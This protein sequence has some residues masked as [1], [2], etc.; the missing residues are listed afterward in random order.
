[1]IK[2]FLICAAAVL[3][4]PAYAEDHSDESEEANRA[5]AIRVLEALASGDVSVLNE[6]FADDGSNHVAGEER[7]RNGPHATFIEAASFVGALSDRKVDVF[8]TLADDNLVTVRSRL[9]GNHTEASIL[10]IEP[11]GRRICGHYTN[12]YRFRDGKIIDNY[13]AN[14]GIQIVRQLR[15]EDQ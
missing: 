15:G 6:V 12:I 9:C 2:S 10:G 14:D 1:M 13:V 3:A 11:S 5:A 4:T 8:E 7:P